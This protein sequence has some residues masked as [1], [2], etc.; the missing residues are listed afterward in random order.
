MMEE[1]TLEQL[2]EMK[3]GIFKTGEIGDYGT[4]WVAVRGGIHDW[5]IYHG[6]VDKQLEWIKRFGDKITEKTTIRSLVPCNDEAFAM[7]RY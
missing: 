2:K 4:K 3:P 5:A 7:Y 6:P 1:L